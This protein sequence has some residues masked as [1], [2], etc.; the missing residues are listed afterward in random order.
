MVKNGQKLI[1]FC[2]KSLNL[3]QGMEMISQGNFLS[4]DPSTGASMSTSTNNPPRCQTPL[5][6]TQTEFPAL[7]RAALK[8]TL[9]IIE[10][11]REAV[12]NLMQVSPLAGHVDMQEHYLA[13]VDLDSFGNLKSEAEMNKQPIAIRELKESAQIALVQQ[14]EYL[15]RFSLAFCERVREDNVLNKAG[16]LK[17]IRDLLVKVRKINSKLSSVLEYHQAMGFDPDKVSLPLK[18]NESKLVPLRGIY[19]CMFST[20]L[21]L[22]HTLLKL[23][24]LEQVFEDLDKVNKK[25][26]NSSMQVDEVKLLRWLG[27]FQEIQAELNACIGCLDDGV[28]QITTLRPEKAKV[29][30][31]KPE[32]V[33]EEPQEI[34]EVIDDLT[35]SPTFDEVFEG[36]TLEDSF[37]KDTEITSELEEN[38]RQMQ[39]QSNRLM[40]ELKGVLTVKAAETEIREA[41]ALARQ[42]RRHND[43]TEDPFLYKQNGNARNGTT[44]GFEDSF[45]P[46]ESSE[47]SSESSECRTVRSASPKS[48][49][50]QT[51][52][53]ARSVSGQLLDSDDEETTSESNDNRLVPP[54]NSLRSLSTPDL[55][56]VEVQSSNSYKS[57]AANEESSSSESDWESADELKTQPLP[58]KRRPLRPKNY[59]RLKEGQQLSLPEAKPIGFETRGGLAAEVAKMARLLRNG[60]GNCEEILGDSSSDSES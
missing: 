27:D 26:K 49:P 28:S 57:F 16:V 43:K 13:F 55:K 4:V 33:Q 59:V 46:D 20:G 47:S 54:I 60:N 14:S 9:Q 36:F 30:Q 11:Y 23:R 52:Q 7:R 10:S 17:H 34:C 35:P 58:V 24:R 40:K 21:H 31:V 2:R 19:T 12:S 38:T 53:I 45:V 37:T 6:G 44:K 29:Q 5:I 18:A 50:P 51:Y 56:A 48:P 42:L 22:Q 3:L 8:C 25:Q 39:K 41:A 32:K 15:R 1:L